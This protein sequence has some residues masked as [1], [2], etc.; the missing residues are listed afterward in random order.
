MP[1]K[2]TVSV[3]AVLYV[4]NPEWVS[5][6]TETDTIQSANAFIEH[7]REIAASIVGKSEGATRREIH[8]QAD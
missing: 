5:A 4:M 1:T 3:F 6:L 8:Q 2:G 7:E